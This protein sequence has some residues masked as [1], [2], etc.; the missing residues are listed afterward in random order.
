MVLITVLFLL[1]F[2]AIG[3]HLFM[4]AYHYIGCANK[5]GDLSED[6]QI[7]QEDYNNIYT[8]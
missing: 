7:C 3:V 2:A 6:S 4:P 8:G 1:I 5:T